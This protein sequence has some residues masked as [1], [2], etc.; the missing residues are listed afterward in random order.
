MAEQYN[1]AYTGQEIDD[2]IG[3]VRSK[4]QTWDQKAAKAAAVTVTLASG[5]WTGNI[6]TVENTAFAAAGYG[7][8]VAPDAASAEDYGS[9]AVRAD[10]VTADGEMT[11]R[12]ANVPDKDLTVDIIIVEVN[13]GERV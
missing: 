4:E 9:C 11:F 2:A 10:D 3:A 1:S 8:F 6:Q 5:N 13:N 7:Y 12:C